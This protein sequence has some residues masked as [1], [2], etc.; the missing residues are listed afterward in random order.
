MNP[1]KGSMENNSCESVKGKGQ[2]AMVKVSEK[3]LEKMSELHQKTSTKTV[4]A[5]ELLRS[6]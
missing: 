1:E 3:R 6:D 2:T 4:N 5:K